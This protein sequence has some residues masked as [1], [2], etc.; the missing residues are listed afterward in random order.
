MFSEHKNE[1]KAE[2]QSRHKYTTKWKQ[3]VYF[4]LNKQAQWE[5]S[6]NYVSDEMKPVCENRSSANVT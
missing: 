3:S 2:I 6:W 1:V 4:K 5:A